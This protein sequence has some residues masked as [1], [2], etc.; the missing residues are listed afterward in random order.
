M[1]PIL[2]A[3]GTTEGQTHKIAEFIAQRLRI[4]GHR[5]DLVDTATPAAHQVQPIYL[6]AI[7]GGSLHQHRHQ[8][9]LAHFI[10]ANISWLGA[11]PVAFYSVSLSAALDDMDSRVEVQRL[12]DEFITECELKP[13]ISR[14]IAGALK[15]TQYDYFKRLLMRMIARQRGQ[16]TDMSKDHEYTDWP[17]VETFVDEYLAA[18]GIA[19]SA[20]A[21]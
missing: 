14:C 1:Q 13:V 2:V 3:Y 7:L 9:S 17:A 19:G 6:G 5:V 11:M 18:A 4:R 8:G 21:G 20:K 12:L 15:Y 10:K 16:T